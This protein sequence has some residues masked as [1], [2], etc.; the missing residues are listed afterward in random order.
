MEPMVSFDADEIRNKKVDVLH[1]VRPIPPDAGASVRGARPVRR[2]L[3]RR[4]ES[5]RLSRGR[6]RAAR[7]TDGDVCG[8]EAVRRQLALAGRAVLSAHGQTP[9]AS[10]F[11]SRHPVPRGAASVVSAEA[12]LDWQPSRLVMSIQ[13]DE[14]IVLRFQAKH[15]GPK[16]HLRPV[17]M[18]FNYRESFA[19]PSPDAYE[20]LLWDVMNNDA[21]LFMRADQVEAA[22]RLLMPV[23]EVWKPVRRAISRTTPAARGDPKPRKVCWSNKGTVGRPPWSWPDTASKAVRDRLNACHFV[24]SWRG[25]RPAKGAAP[26]RHA[27]AP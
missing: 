19:T 22:W 8:V 3:D 2:G 6:R 16:M 5:A 18:Q 12:T 10:G 9:P 13:P 4:Q 1:A 27:F 25:R 26:F 15:P 23:L 24:R 11:G 21:T 7:F 20:T 17:D 14:G